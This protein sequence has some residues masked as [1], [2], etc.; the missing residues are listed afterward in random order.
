MRILI[1]GGAGM[2]GHTLVEAFRSRIRD[3][4][5]LRGAVKR[6]RA[7]RTVRSEP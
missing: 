2:L 6:R 1:L 4:V 7:G 3:V 5:T